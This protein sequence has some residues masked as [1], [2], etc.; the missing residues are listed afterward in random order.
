MEIMFQFWGFLYFTITVVILLLLYFIWMPYIREVRDLKESNFDYYIGF[1][2][3]QTWQTLGLIF[4][5]IASTFFTFMSPQV[6]RKSVKHE[7]AKSVKCYRTLSAAELRQRD[8]T[9]EE[10]DKPKPSFKQQMQE[11][12]ASQRERNRNYVDQILEGN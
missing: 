11:E 2:K 3:K 4:L 6:D 12:A 5:M 7:Q 9:K 10:N 8:A 1:P